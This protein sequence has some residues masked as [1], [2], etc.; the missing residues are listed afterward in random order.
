MRFAYIDSHGNEVP[1]PSVDALA[2]RIELGAVGP[3]T[4]LYDAQADHWGPA[5]THE[6]FH[7]LARDA[8]SDSGFVAPPPP[9]AP[10]P[11]AAPR[12][13]PPAAAPSKT[14]PAS[15]PKPK[16]KQ[17]EP[18]TAADLGLTLAAP[19]PEPPEKT[20]ALEP[21][22]PSLDLSLDLAPPMDI[23]PQGRTP[24]PGLAAGEGAGFGETFD[25]G[26]LGSGLQLEDSGLAAPGSVEGLG[27]GMSMQTP[28]QFG[29]GGGPG[30]DLQLEQPMSAFEPDSPPGWMTESPGGGV[31]D[32]SVAPAPAAPEAAPVAPRAEASARQRKEPKDRPST[33]KFKKQRNLAGP[34]IFVVLILALGVGG[35]VGWPLVQARLN[36]PEAPV[37]PA[38][39]MPA[40]PPELVARM[41]AL[42]EGAIAEAI[43]EVDAATT[44]A[45]SPIEPDQQWLAGRYLADAGQYAGVEAFWTSM[46]DFVEGVRAAEW[47]LYRE[48]L[49]ARV[50]A[51]GLAEDTAAMIV[52]RADSGFVAAEA[53][54]NEAYA[55]LDRVVVAAL[56]LHEY[57]VA[58]EANIEY[59]P[60]TTST[61]DPILEAVPNNSSIGD[62]M[63]EM[64]DEITQALADLGSLDRVTRQRLT[65]ALTTR[66][67][68]VG[69][70]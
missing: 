45:G 34:I 29:A 47:Q 65:S 1:I 40:I 21:A 61:A 32:F 49:V 54:R 14:K 48:K 64:V 66:L 59:R 33:P 53:A 20:S 17:P 13:A 56:S 15:P 3:E 26:D 67:Q 69:V 36:Q 58:N 57:L 4:Q 24:D 42:A 25:Y 22:L 68:Q 23:Q 41:R 38:V 7:T 63:L 18:A 6:I 16:P 5:N 19:Q 44:V 70:Q 39:V 62:R 10:P 8:Q 31:M 2:L 46:A 28:M 9:V 52:E 51:D 55:T 43:A 27:G 30:G 12:P 35:Y 50:A 60:A 11:R 37:R